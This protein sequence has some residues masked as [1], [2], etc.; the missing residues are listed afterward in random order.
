MMGVNILP[1]VGCFGGQISGLVFLGEFPNS[2]KL[3]Y[4]LPYGILPRSNQAGNVTVH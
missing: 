4:Y 2:R 3:R 1:V